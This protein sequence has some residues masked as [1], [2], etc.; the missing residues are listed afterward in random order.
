MTVATRRVP[1]VQR[2]VRVD[3][4]WFD[5][6][7]AMGFKELAAYLAHYT[8]FAVYLSQKKEHDVQQDQ[9]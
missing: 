3:C 8:A 2:G 7:C 9:Q 5:E 6:W 4:Y 1:P